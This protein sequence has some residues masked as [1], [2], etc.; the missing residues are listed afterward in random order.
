MEGQKEEL[1]NL[2]NK[3]LLYKLKKYE[4]KLLNYLRK[5]FKKSNTDII[6]EHIEHMEKYENEYNEAVKKENKNYEIKSKEI[7]NNRQKELNVIEEKKNKVIKDNKTLYNDILSYLE[8]IKDDKEKLINFF[9][10]STLFQI[11]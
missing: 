2:E 11:N 6:E 10:N 1:E 4:K 8:S 9:N 5:L 3:N 7:S